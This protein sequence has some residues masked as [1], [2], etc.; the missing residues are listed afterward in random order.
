MAKQ[1]FGNKLVGSIAWLFIGIFIFLGSF[2]VLYKGVVRVNYAQIAE[3]AVNADQ[4]Q[5]EKAFVYATGEIESESKIGDGIYLNDGD[6]IAFEKTAEMYAW[7]ENVEHEN[8]DKIYTYETKWVEDVPLSGE[9]EKPED[10]RNPMKTEKN[11]RKIVSEAQINGYKID[12]DD[13]KLPPLQPLELSDKNIQLLEYQTIV[14]NEHEYVFDGYGT[15]EEPEVGDFRIRYSALPEGEKVTVFG[16]LGN[17]EI[18]QHHDNKKAELYRLFLGE[19]EDAVSTLESEYE[20]AGWIYRVAGFLLMWI[21]LLL[22]LKPL[23]VAVEFLPF[24]SNLGKTAIT[25]I[26]FLTALVITIVAYILLTIFNTVFVLLII[27]A[28][29]V[30]IWIYINMIKTSASKK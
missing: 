3:Q 10:H 26:T 12:V 21:G 7:V 2:Y 29:V 25:I 1:T 5:Q 4:A 27:L 28:L 18:E 9:F 13:V 22:M 30:G 24:L 11:F 19:K 6:Y 15:Y 14:S 20:V 16:R 17:N 8:G 23:T